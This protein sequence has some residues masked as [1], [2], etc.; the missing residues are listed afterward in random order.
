MTRAKEQFSQK[1]SFSILAVLF[2]AVFAFGLSGC[3][4]G[5]G[6]SGRNDPGIIQCPDGSTVPVGTQCPVQCPDGST[7]PAG[8][9]CPV[10][11]TQC[12]DGSTV[13]VGTQCPVQCPDGSTVPA[14]TQCPVQMT[15]CPD[16]STVPVGTQCPVQMT[17]CPDGSTVP[18]GTQCPVQCPDGSTV[19]AGTQCPVQMT[20]CP[21]G[22][23]VPV[24]TQCPVQMTQCPDGSTVPVGTQCPVQCPDGSTV[25]AGTQC[26]VQMT[27]CPDGSTVP[28][29]TQCPVQCPDGS[30]VPV[31]TQ[32]PVD[33]IVCP[34]GESVPVGQECPPLPHETIR[35]RRMLNAAEML[36]P[37]LAADAIRNYLRATGVGARPRTR[38]TPTATSPTFSSTTQSSNR[39]QDG[40]TEDRWV[41][42]A[43]YDSNGQLFFTRSRRT[44]TQHFLSHS[45]DSD[46]TSNR[47]DDL[48][49]PGWKGVETEADYT[50]GL[51]YWDAFSDIENAQDADYLTLGYWLIVGRD[52]NTGQLSGSIVGV[53]GGGS[54]GFISANLAGLT[55]TAS[56]EGPA[57]GVVMSRENATAAPD[58]L[59][60]NAKAS[61]TADFGDATAFG[62]ISG[63]IIEGMTEGGDAL[64]EVTLGSAAI[65]P[66]SNIAGNGGNYFGD[67]SG[68][69]DAGVAFSGKWGGKFYSNGASATDHPGS[70]AGTFGAKTTDDLQAILG[71]FGAYKQ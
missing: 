4:G 65:L 44:S 61:L 57:T 12:P 45:N 30:T 59:Y 25:P 60:F 66:N 46:V 36:S 27:Q 14:G 8:T 41:F 32:C 55:G 20:Q 5:G 43:E 63:R 2:V 52:S 6:S 67:T 53:S 10:Q 47:L 70:V 21:D 19:P 54:D 29:G 26:P 39:R 42:Q 9:Q 51:L 49:S 69:T 3:G 40:R 24:G 56:Y 18:V 64:P 22:S 37:S 58:V 7:V 17:Q 68:M 28:V 16:G 33:E 48:P 23:T 50:G 1:M 35:Q 71:A 11:M 62:S 13:P 31:G 34:A 15:Q 38:P